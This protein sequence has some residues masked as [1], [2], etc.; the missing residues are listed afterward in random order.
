M[1]NRENE[2][3]DLIRKNPMITQN[4]LA[5]KLEIARSSVAV[6][7]ANLMKKGLIKGKRYIL[8]ET[9][10]IC[11]IGGSNVDIQGFP[12][13]RLVLADSNPGQIKISFGGVGRNIAENTSRMSIPTKLITAV[14]NDDYGQSILNQLKISEIDCQY[15]MVSDEF[16]TSTYLPILDADG[17]M[18]AAISQMDVLKKLDIDFIERRRQIVKNA[19]LC[20]IDANLPEESIEYLTAS[21][22]GKEFFFD[23]VSTAKAIKA[24]NILDKLYFIKPNKLEAEKLAGIAIG[25]SDDLRR[26][27]SHFLEKGVK[28][29]VISLGNGGNYYN[30]GNSEFVLEA[31]KLDVVNATGAGDAFMAGLVYS[32]LE[33]FS[34]ELTVKFATAASAMALSHANTVNP[35]ISVE[36]INK[37]MERMNY[38]KRLS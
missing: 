2:I 14:G 6:H 4:E 27:G 5:E 38:V 1:T 17:D 15:S 3:I 36:N 13:E 20:V 18:K 34:A 9:P 19:R 35:N 11:V 16:P 32:R 23:T 31:D 22:P 30:D 12:N 26:C 37:V 7:I 24:K 28:H 29:V 10:Y 21:F 33:E 25:N 8:D